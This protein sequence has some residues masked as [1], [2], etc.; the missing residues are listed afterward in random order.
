MAK[1]REQPQMQPDAAQS[2][3][4]AAQAPVFSVPLRV[5]YQHTDAGG[6]VHHAHYLNFMEHAR[7]EWMR[8]LGFSQADM[9]RFGVMFAVRAVKIDFMKPARLDDA[10]Q[11]SVC[12]L[13]AGGASL[14]L[15][16]CIQRDDTVLCRGEVKL[17]CLDC[18]SFS[19]VVIPDAVNVRMA[20]WRSA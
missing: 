3:P 16:Q 5:Y 1:R 8:T 18:Q 7:T 20:P 11:A 2:A 19:P 17:A 12:L 9:A 6:V 13:R 14:L 4:A 10:L 15:E